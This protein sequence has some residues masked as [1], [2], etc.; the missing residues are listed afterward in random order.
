MPNSGCFLSLVFHQNRRLS[1]R[2]VFSGFSCYITGT[3]GKMDRGAREGLK[4]NG[5]MFCMSLNLGKMDRGARERGAT[6]SFGEF[7]DE[8]IWPVAMPVHL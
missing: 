2:L 7:P 5:S 3:A 8:S 6:N 1:E 4:L